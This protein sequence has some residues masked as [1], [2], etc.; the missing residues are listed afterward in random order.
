MK[1]LLFFLV[2]LACLIGLR[3]CDP[4]SNSI[5]RDEVLRN[6]VKIELLHYE[7]QTPQLVKLDGKHKPVF[8]FSKTTPIATL[9]DSRIEDVVSDIAQQDL[10]LWGRTLNEPIGKTLILYQK[11]GNMLV[12]FGCVYQSENGQTHYYGHCNLYDQ[13][14]MFIEYLGDIDSDYVDTLESRY[15]E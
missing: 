11:N 9:D 8:A 12:L 1:K 5:D 14:G 10:L 15:F 2:M 7:N 3:G 4:A 13:N 6:T